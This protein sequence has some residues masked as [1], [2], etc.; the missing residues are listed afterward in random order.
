MQYTPRLCIDRSSHSN[1]PRSNSTLSTFF[2]TTFTSRPAGSSVMALWFTTSTNT[3]VSAASRSIISVIHAVILSFADIPQSSRST[4][5]LPHTVRMS[6]LSKPV[7]IF[8][9]R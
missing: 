6:F 9:R 2:C 7:S 4:Q 8:L 5:P 3:R 1:L